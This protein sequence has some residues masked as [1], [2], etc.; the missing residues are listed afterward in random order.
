MGFLTLT[1]TEPVIVVTILLGNWQSAIGND[2]STPTSSV[3][4]LNAPSLLL[5]PNH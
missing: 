4:T 2:F 5:V 1:L 3:G